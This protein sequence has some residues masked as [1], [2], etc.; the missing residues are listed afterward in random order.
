MKLKF[1]LL[2]VFVII[3]MLS[4]ANVFAQSSSTY[5]RNGIGDLMFAYS[6]RGLGIGQAGVALSDR[7]FVS[8]IN[9]ASWNKLHLTRME[10]GVNYI[11]VN[12]ADNNNSSFYSTGN[13]SGFTIAFPV[14][15]TYG[16]G[17]A[18]GMVPYSYTNY[19]VNASGYQSDFY[20]KY[21]ILY[22]GSG[23]LSKAFIGSSFKFANDFSIGATFDYYFGNLFYSSEVSF[24]DANVV[25]SYHEKEIKPRGLGTTLGLITPDFSSFLSSSKIKDLRLGVS[26]NI[27]SKLK[28]DTMMLAYSTNTY[29]TLNYGAMDLK[30]PM[31]LNLGLSFVYADNYQF[32]MDY[33]TQAWKDYKAGDNSDPNLQTLNR[34]VAGF[35][36]KPPKELGASSFGQMMWRAAVGYEQTQYCLNGKGINYM[37][38]SGGFSYPL[39]PENTLDIGVQYGQRGTKDNGLMKENYFKLTAGFSL[40]ELWFF[41][42]DK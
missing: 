5:S 38:V 42:M 32:F 4:A 1:N 16:V 37:F 35:E 41:R 30:I 34:V 10:F 33:A 6:G 40:G 18:A 12:I 22:K 21:S 14:S 27:I 20:G 2:R 11:G 31:R 15:A 25:T 28:A 9:P 23:G 39:S 13:F 26:A 24:E 8:I 3:G 19:K 36:Y 17:L 29:D 7:D